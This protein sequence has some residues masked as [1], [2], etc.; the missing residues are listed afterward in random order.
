MR[1]CGDRC[2]QAAR[3][4]RGDSRRERSGERC[5]YSELET[6]LL[7]AALERRLWFWDSGTLIFVVRDVKKQNFLCNPFGGYIE[8][9]AKYLSVFA[10]GSIFEIRENALPSTV[11]ANNTAKI[12]SKNK[13][14]LAQGGT[15][16]IFS[17][18]PQSTKV[19]K[20]FEK[21][22]FNA[23]GSNTFTLTE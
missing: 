9:G 21:H 19:K 7:N 6:L 4:E 11:I 17:R 8:A 14:V 2:A 22:G 15:A 1:R 3:R 18:S 16:T 20:T 5:G 10:D 12:A 13:R 23:S